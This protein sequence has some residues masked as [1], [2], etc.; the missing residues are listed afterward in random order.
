MHKASDAHDNKHARKQPNS[1]APT[2]S[3]VQKWQCV[4]RPLKKYF[5]VG[6]KLASRAPMASH[7]H[8]GWMACTKGSYRHPWTAHTYCCRNA[9]Q[10]LARVSMHKGMDGLSHG[11]FC[12]LQLENARFRF[13]HTQTRA[14]GHAIQLPSQALPHCLSKTPSLIRQH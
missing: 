7:K 5:W 8:I 13:S 10:H 1:R 11:Y 14:S 12:P 4:R 2:T 6:R 3:Q 9:M